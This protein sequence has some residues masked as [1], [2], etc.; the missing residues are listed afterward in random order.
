METQRSMLNGKTRLRPLATVLTVA[1]IVGAVF[2]PTRAAT[3][4]VNL[5]GLADAPSA[6]GEVNFRF[7]GPVMVGGVHVENL[8]PQP[9]GSGRFYGVWFVRLDTDDKA[10]LGALINNKSII[11]SATG[12]GQSSGTGV[13]EFRATQFTTGPHAGSPITLGAPE[14]NL[15]IVLIEKTINGLTPDPVGMAASGTF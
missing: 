3:S 8:P 12:P 5:V 2:T 9:F 1:L 14:K 15:F 6:I 13:Q 7:A 11:F 4:H 10:F